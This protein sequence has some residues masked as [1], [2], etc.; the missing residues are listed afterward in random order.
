MK[1]V[2]N[3][4]NNIT[5]YRLVLYF[6]IVLSVVGLVYSLTGVYAFDPINYVFSFTFLLV[7]SGIA[8]KIFTKVFEAQANTES[9]II[10]ALIL[11]LIIAPPKNL[12]EVIFLG[13]AGVL[14]V[15]SKFVLSIGNKH[16]FNPVAISVAVTSMAIQGNA[17]WW[18]GQ[19]S[20][21]PIVAMGGFLIVRKIKRWDMV[22]AFLIIALLWSGPTRLVRS[23]ADT[24]LIFFAAIMLTEPLTTPPTKTLRMLYG[25][26]VGF[27]IAPQ[28]H[29]GNVFT[30]PE[31]ALIIGN[32]YS[33]WVSPKYKLILILKEKI[34]LTHDV[35]DFVFVPDKQ[36]NFTPGQY[37]EFTLEHSK[38]DD[39]GNRRYLSL[40]SSPFDKEIRIGVK[41][42]F[43]PSSFKKGLMAME[44]GE[45]IVA[46]QL[47][48]DFIL[49][50]DPSRKLVFMAGGIGITPFRSMVKYLIDINQKRDI[51]IVYSAKTVSEFVY[52]NVFKEAWDKLGIRTIYIDSENQGHI[53]AARLS[54]EIPDYKERTFYISGSHGV[55]DS[56]E[57]ILKNLHV[58]ARQVVTDYFPGFA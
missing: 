22:L 50:K 26:L 18:V 58:P 42:G 49:P 2:D 5:M 44:S 13:W 43:P 25:A 55:V 32:I 46:G 1:L 27:L 41:F 35:F 21:L 10:S 33:F 48:G 19:A 52:T 9:W 8:N 40:A 31:L 15:T 7:V 38:P 56:F 57:Q 11:G 47:I 53:D 12:H 6:L 23:I 34:K 51:V 28:M 37:M 54:R 20:M 3:F 36:I 4:L 29:F 30:T 24:P 17:N 39:R 16:I 14:M 45:K